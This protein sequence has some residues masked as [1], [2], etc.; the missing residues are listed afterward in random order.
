MKSLGQ[1][2]N[3]ALRHTASATMRDLLLV[4]VT[5]VAAMTAYVLLALFE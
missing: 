1:L 5:T 4:C 3:T 2:A